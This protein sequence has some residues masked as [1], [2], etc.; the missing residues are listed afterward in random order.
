[1]GGE[2]GKTVGK[3]EKAVKPSSTRGSGNHSTKWKKSKMVIGSGQNRVAFS[4]IG[5]NER[6]GMGPEKW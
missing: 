2:P 4:F 5:V 3:K 1:M 6:P